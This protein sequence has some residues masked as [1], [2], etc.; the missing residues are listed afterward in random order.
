VGEFPIVCHLMAGVIMGMDGRAINN[1]RLGSRQL[2]KYWPS[3]WVGAPVKATL[4]DSFT[5]SFLS[6]CRQ[7]NFGGLF[8]LSRL[9]CSAKTVRASTLIP[10][11]LHGVIPLLP[12]LRYFSLI[13]AASNE[14]SRTLSMICLIGRFTKDKCFDI[15]DCERNFGFFGRA[16]I[17][18]GDIW[19]AK[20]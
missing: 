2:N 20:S 19:R 10:L 14:S 9:E 17:F 1:S 6:L 15:R 8:S 12:A 18:N 16:G 4:S 13:I 5:L 11:L 7:S 3:L